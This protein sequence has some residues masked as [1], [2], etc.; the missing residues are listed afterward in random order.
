MVPEAK[1][2]LMD[3]LTLL[4]HWWQLRAASAM[5]KAGHKLEEVVKTIT[6]SPGRYCNLL[7][8]T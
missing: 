4:G 8:L 3:T 6:T 2:T 5:M 1:L 7:F